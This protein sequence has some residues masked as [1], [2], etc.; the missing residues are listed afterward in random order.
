MSVG[1]GTP[2]RR[3]P[4][5]PPDH[6]MTI[7]LRTVNNIIFNHLYYKVKKKENEKN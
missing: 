3:M 5:P 2:L 4:Q 6:A 1:S 7:K